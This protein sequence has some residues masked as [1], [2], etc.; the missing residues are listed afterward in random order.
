VNDPFSGERIQGAYDIAAEDY[1]SAFGNDLARLPLD[2]R[3]LDEA[4]RAA[5]DGCLLDIGCGTGSAGSYLTQCG[6]R[7]IGVD[8][9]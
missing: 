5:G 4:C 2:C 7:V 1:E 6:A 9:S 8:L 3:M